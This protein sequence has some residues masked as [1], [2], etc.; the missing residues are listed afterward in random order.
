MSENL[1]NGRYLMIFLKKPYKNEFVHHPFV[2]ISEMVSGKICIIFDSV[3][4]GVFR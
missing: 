4:S 1:I 2:K 3:E